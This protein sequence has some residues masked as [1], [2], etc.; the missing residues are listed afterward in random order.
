MK[1]RAQISGD[2]GEIGFGRRQQVL[3]LARALAREIGIAAVNADSKVPK[4][5]EVKFPSC[6]G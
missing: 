3:A 6:R 5:A 2:D 4:C 1:E